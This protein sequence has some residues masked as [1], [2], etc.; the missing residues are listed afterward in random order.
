MST[1]TIEQNHENIKMKLYLVVNPY[2]EHFQ[3]CVCA[4]S[5][6]LVRVKPTWVLFDWIQHHFTT[7]WLYQDSAA[8]LS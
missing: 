6:Y 5:L 8:T 4:A 3:L 1:F 7:Y 2:Q